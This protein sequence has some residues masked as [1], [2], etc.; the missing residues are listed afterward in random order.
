VVLTARPPPPCWNM[1]FRLDL[2]LPM[3]VG[4][5]AAATSSPRY[6][7]ISIVL[8]RV[9][10]SLRKRTAAAMSI[11]A[12]GGPLLLGVLLLV[13]LLLVGLSLGLSSGAGGAVDADLG[14]VAGGGTNVDSMS[15]VTVVLADLA[16][17]TDL[18]TSGP[19]AWL[20][21]T[22]PECMNVVPKADSR[23]EP[24]RPR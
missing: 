6:M 3:W 12:T 15:A 4:E 5:A 17:L 2:S 1:V 22:S 19:G 21:S 11:L 13:L 10:S 16:D 23:F 18:G 20:V 14:E 24:F 8:L 9:L 7:A